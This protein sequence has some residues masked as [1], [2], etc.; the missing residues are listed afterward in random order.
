MNYATSKSCNN[1]KYLGSCPANILAIS[2]VILS[3]KASALCGQLLM[4]Q[5]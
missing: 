4:S 3:V 2:I 5:C 1:L